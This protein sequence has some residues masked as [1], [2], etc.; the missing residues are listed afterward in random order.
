M[1][2]MIR[3]ILELTVIIPGMLLA[4]LPVNECLKQAPVKLAL[5]LT[6]LLLTLSLSGGL[7][8]Y[9]LQ[10]SV[11]LLLVPVLMLLMLIYHKTLQISIWKSSSIFLAVCAVFACVNSLSRACLLY[12]S[13][14]DC[15]AIRAIMSALLLY[16]QRQQFS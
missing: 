1:M 15:T 7:V 6:T 9:M 3:P 10:L 14:A 8:C 12:T 2:E 16:H 4:Y 13:R 5:W 11:K